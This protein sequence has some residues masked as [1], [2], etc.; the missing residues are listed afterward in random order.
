MCCCAA[1]R[2]AAS[3]LN[4]SP[5]F[6]VGIGLNVQQSAD[7]FAAAELPDATSLAQ[8]TTAPLD[9]PVIAAKLIRRL[10]ADYEGLCQRDLVTLETCWRERLNLL[11][12]HV[13]AECPDAT[14]RGR[15]MDLSFRGVE[16]ERTDKSFL[17]LAPERIQHLWQ[18]D[19]PLGG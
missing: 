9:T 11:G 17:A 5:C 10:D 2:Y 19:A 16:L 3:S 14:H 7:V 1:V 12:K 8:F 13:I 15:V 4:R 6:I 18:A